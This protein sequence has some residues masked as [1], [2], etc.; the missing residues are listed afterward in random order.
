MGW[1]A[2]CERHPFAQHVSVTHP[3]RRT[4]AVERV[5]NGDFGEAGPGDPKDPC[6]TEMS[7]TQT[8][9]D[10]GNTPV[11]A[12]KAERLASRR[13][14]RP[15]WLRDGKVA[16]ATRRDA[17]SWTGRGSRVYLHW[18]HIR[19]HP[20]THAMRVVWVVWEEWRRNLGGSELGVRQAWGCGAKVQ[21][22]ER[23][24]LGEPCACWDRRQ[25][26]VVLL[27]RV[28]SQAYARREAL[29]PGA[30]KG[31]PRN[32]PFC[33]G[34]PTAAPEPKARPTPRPTVP[35]GGAARQGEPSAIFTRTSRS[36]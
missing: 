10:I 28:A 20:R 26:L 13:R 11:H 16:R 2:N 36:W 6:Q 32:L 1:A 31:S 35:T 23:D 4:A 29:H 19:M 8:P 24:L 5:G 34:V 7:V 22:A 27:R 15:V 25:L 33:N 9:D 21:G 12:A 30:R 14:L 18:A 17:E 3:G